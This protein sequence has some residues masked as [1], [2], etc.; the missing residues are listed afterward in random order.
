MPK[1][2]NA[3]CVRAVVCVQHGP[4]I[5][6]LLLAS[7]GFAHFG[8]AADGPPTEKAAHGNAKTEEKGAAD[9]KPD[10]RL[11]IDLST[12]EKAL[13]AHIQAFNNRDHGAIF[14]MATKACQ[15]FY[16]FETSFALQV[17]REPKF[18]E[19]YRKYVDNDKLL[20][21]YRQRVPRDVAPEDV[22]L[23]L[24][25][26][27]TAAA[28][29][30]QRG[31]FLA[32]GVAF[33]ELDDRRPQIFKGKIVRQDQS[34]ADACATVKGD[35]GA[36]QIPLRFVQQNGRWLEDIPADDQQRCKADP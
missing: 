21:I 19:L 29:A 27:M 28:I 23:R 8:A 7:L 2:R 1:N 15:E 17:K 35:D 18:K 22:D 5:V 30:D 24:T 34:T 9:P 26:Q 33:D 16:L 31:F 10:A 12:P 13:Q 36:F 32:A 20:Q 25:Y 6:V 11:E 3:P 14:D 4:A